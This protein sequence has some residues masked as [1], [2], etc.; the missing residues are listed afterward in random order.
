MPS[1]TVLLGTR[2][3]LVG[4]SVQPVS[5]ERQWMLRTLVVLQAPRAVF[6]ALRDDSDEAAGARQEPVL[7]IMW[8]AGIA[9]VL[10]TPAARTLLDDRLFD[11]LVVAVWAFIGGG[12]YGAL[13]FWLGGALVHRATLA[14]G[15]QGSYRRA[16][17]VVAFACAPIALS[18]VVLWP[19]GLAAFGGDLFRSG[20]SDTDA[21]G[22]FFLWSALA[23][24]VWALA[25]LAVGIRA[26]HGWT[27]PRSLAALGISVAALGAVVLVAWA[28]HAGGE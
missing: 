24:G 22:A 17:H 7:A 12:F 26:V 14:L 20:G 5:L 18:L 11:G 8:L 16:R 15:G 19:I 13:A 27:W 1:N 3:Y 25:L 28:L 9:G 23:F 4:M 21:G 2:D 10:A 6:A